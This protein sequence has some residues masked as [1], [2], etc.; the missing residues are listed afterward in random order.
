MTKPCVFRKSR[1]DAPNRVLEFSII[2][3]AVPL[4]VDR[5]SFKTEMDELRVLFGLG[6]D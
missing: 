6:A 2:G 3:E 4:E 5:V 1:G